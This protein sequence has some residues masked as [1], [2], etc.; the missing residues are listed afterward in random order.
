[1]AKTIDLRTLSV[2]TLNQKVSDLFPL[3]NKKIKA[4]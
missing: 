4:K 1:M 3:P 2:E